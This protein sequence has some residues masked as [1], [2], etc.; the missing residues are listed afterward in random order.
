MTEALLQ[1]AIDAIRRGDKATGQR[2]LAQMLRAD[3]RSET[4]WLWMSQIVESDA[5]R[6]DCLRR[7]LAINPDNA[8]ARKGVALLEARMRGV[9][10]PAPAL[11]RPAPPAQ[12]T[13][14]EPPPQPAITPPSSS[15]AA[16]PY[17]GPEP[18]PPD[19][20]APQVEPTIVEPAAGARHLLMPTAP[21]VEPAPAIEQAPQGMA[22]A[23]AVPARVEE[24]SRRVPETRRVERRPARRRP[25]TPILILVLIVVAG[26]AAAYAF[27]SSRSSEPVAA[28][29]VTTT[30]RL[31]ASLDQGG[32]ADLAL[33]QS[34]SS[35][36]TSLLRR[37]GADIDPAWSPDGTRIA[38]TAELGDA[39]VIAV[40]EA[41]GQGFT[42]LTPGDV[43][44]VDPAWSPDGTRI[45]FASDREGDFDIYVMNSDGTGALNLTRFEGDDRAPAWSPDGRTIVFQ[46]NREGQIDIY[47]MDA[48][49]FG[50]ARLTSDPAD[51]TDPSVSP[52]GS[53]IAFI[54]TRGGDADVFVMDPDG[55]RSSGVTRNDVDDRA[56]SW[57]PHEAI[58]FTSV[59]TDGTALFV[60]QPDGSGSSRV[61]DGVTGVSSAAWQ[62]ID[63][64]PAALTAGATST[65]LGGGQARAQAAP[66][67][68]A[69]PFELPEGAF[70]FASN[71]EGQFDL[72][73]MDFGGENWTVLSDLPND[74]RH[75]ALSPA[76]S[77]LVFEVA[78]TDTQ[79]I[80]VVDLSSPETGVITLTQGAEP[81][82]TAR[83][84]PDGTLIAYEV[85][86]ERGP[87]VVLVQPD[88]S[89]AAGLISR[90]GYDGC[91]S[92][93]PE[94]EQIAFTSDHDGDLNVYLMNVDGTDLKRLTQHAGVDR[95]PA[96][97]PDG[98]RIAFISNRN[99]EGV[100]L[101]D[102]KGAN[103][104]LLAALSGASQPAWSP[105]G[106]FLLVASDQDGDFDVYLIAVD[107]A[108]IWNLTADSKADEVDPI[109]TR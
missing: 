86:A 73:S 25:T 66:T 101:T 67:A 47:R 32:D 89:G 11:A 33:I 59:I 15:V 24:E 37:D 106:R 44:S 83:W 100:Y 45:A 107:E 62:P 88:G 93:R 53:R 97:S 19:I 80:F 85:D 61:A 28:P 55:T 72:F 21:A 99:G 87:D 70:A 52:D 78:F 40:V 58:L 42:P 49:G 9:P 10:P 76:G 56:P 98:A 105:D 7:I 23:S 64:D 38:F 68:I 71:R 75:P 50:V 14:A 2:L 60:V 26:G 22:E 57:N 39:L 27:F 108:S 34:D 90:P 81:A 91:L 13:P 54:S 96:W 95:C 109:W 79:R 102:A 82:H 74:K 12:P 69:P 41:N 35:N 18:A 48:G 46:S 94:D 3:P 31:V 103:V 51:D 16:G 6:L 65:P 4:A 1:Q 104:R 8:A 5:Q 77:Q 20:P 29:V 43:H 17:A 92:W 63:V 84:S 36:V 30:G